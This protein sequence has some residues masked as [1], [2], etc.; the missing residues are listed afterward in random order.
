[1]DGMEP[2]KVDV[3]KESND[4]GSHAMMVEET[5]FKI[6]FDKCCNFIL[7]N[8]AILQVIDNVEMD[9]VNIPKEDTTLR[10]KAMLLEETLESHSCIKS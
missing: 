7:I 10:P 9:F 5:I 4:I 6:Y 2:A 1:M 3:P 8:V